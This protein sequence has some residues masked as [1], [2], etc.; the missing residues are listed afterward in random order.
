M[1]DVLKM[2]RE[3]VGLHARLNWLYEQDR[4]DSVEFEDAEWDFNCLSL[5][6][7]YKVLEI[8]KGADHPD[9]AKNSPVWFLY[10]K[11]SENP[12]GGGGQ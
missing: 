9:K 4:Q 6:L 11:S 1:S 5:E 3:I 7:A 10:R 8:A 2:A 12:E